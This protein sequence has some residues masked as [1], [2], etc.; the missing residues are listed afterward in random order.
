MVQYQ[1]IFI[2][3]LHQMAAMQVSKLYHTTNNLR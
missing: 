1:F 3:A 2:V